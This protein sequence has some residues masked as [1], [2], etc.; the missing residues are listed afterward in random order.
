M[1]ALINVEKRERA[2]VKNK[3][4]T[5]S[6]I[7]GRKTWKYFIAADRKWEMLTATKVKMSDIKKVYRN[8]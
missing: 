7:I 1:S 5:E 2:K 6:N 8:T 3:E 4:T